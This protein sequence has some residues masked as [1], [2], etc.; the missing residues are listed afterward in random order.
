M[1]SHEMCEGR[2]VLE[3]VG[4]VADCQPTGCHEDQYREAEHQAR[5][6]HADGHGSH[7]KTISGHIDGG[8]NPERHAAHAQSGDEGDEANHKIGNFDGK[9]RL[10]EPGLQIGKERSNLHI[11]R[12]IPQKPRFVN[13]GGTYCPI[14]LPAFKAAIR[15]SSGG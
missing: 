3:A 9:P 7:G 13:P 5:P 8:K 4:V 14:P 12:T 15:S 10:Q 11:A 6:H 1:P 2:R